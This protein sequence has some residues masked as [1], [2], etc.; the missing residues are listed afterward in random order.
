MSVSEVRRQAAEDLADFGQRLE[1]SVTVLLEHGEA[2]E[3]SE[4]T[5]RR[6]VSAATRLC[7]A[8]TEATGQEVNP[9]HDDVIATEAIVLACAL[10]KARDLNPFDLALWFSR[11]H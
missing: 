1:Q 3:V 5:V 6:L 10:L 7:A 9:L 11:S 4:E 2:T 8:R